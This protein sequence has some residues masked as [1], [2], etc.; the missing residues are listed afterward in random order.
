MTDTEM[1]SKLLEIETQLT[2]MQRVLGKDSDETCVNEVVD[3]GIALE[4]PWADT[5]AEYKAR[6][7]IAHN[8]HQTG[9]A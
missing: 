3:L 8:Q 1:Q 4:V 6:V 9:A 2:E 5:Y 7:K